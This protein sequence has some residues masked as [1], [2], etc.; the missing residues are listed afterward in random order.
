MERV[1]D[2]VIYLQFLWSLLQHKWY[3][4]QAGRL[5]GVSLWTRIIHD[6]SKFTPTEFFRYARNFHGDYSQSPNDR[7]KVSLEFTYAWLHHENSNPH[8]W[9]HWIPRT[10]KMANEPLAMPE[11][12]VREMI[13]DCLGASK[14]Y[15]GSWNIAVWLNENGPSWQ[16]HCETERLI[17]TI[18]IELGYFITDNCLWSWMKL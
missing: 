18:L 14:A 7:E 9:G 10:G 17:A 11:K 6:W 16:L 4:F 8:H 13:A 15:T 1:R 2:I 5:T 12:Y 3:F